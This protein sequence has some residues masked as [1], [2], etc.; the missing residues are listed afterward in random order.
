MAVIKKETF[1]NAPADKVWATLINDPNR[2]D[3][4]LTPVRALEERVTGSVREGLEFHITLGKIGGAKIKVVEAVPGRLLR[5][6]AGP[7]MM[8]MMGMPMRGTL[9]LEPRDGST[10]VFLKMVTPMM[11]APMMGMMSGLNPNE[12]MTKTIERIKRESEK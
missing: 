4:W 7:G 12:E 3:E 6:N 10:H 1:V 8:H 5:W 11:M 2:W 9:E